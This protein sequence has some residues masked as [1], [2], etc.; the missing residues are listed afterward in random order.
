[1]NNSALYNYTTV[2]ACFPGALGINCGVIAG[3][4]LA[5]VAGVTAGA[6]A[7]ICLA[8][9]ALLA[10]ACGGTYAV[11]SS[12][13]A[14]TDQTVLYNPLYEDQEKNQNPLWK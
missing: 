7:G 10:I 5:V 8:A 6:I 3:S 12:A 13:I 4:D 9:L 14:E 2:C 11:A 1:L